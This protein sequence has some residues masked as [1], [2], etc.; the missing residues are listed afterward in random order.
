[1]SGATLSTKGAAEF[2]GTTPRHMK[3]LRAERR[4]PVWHQEIVDP[5]NY[6]ANPVTYEVRDLTAWQAGRVIHQ[7]PEKIEPAS[8]VDL[9]SAWVGARAT[10]R[11]GGTTV[12]LEKARCWGSAWRDSLTGARITSAR[13]AQ[14]GFHLTLT[15]ARP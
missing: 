11:L 9:E 4:G 12:L 6:R 5:E 1:M 3:K 7:E 8:A 15:G 10:S 14:L 2:L 13:A